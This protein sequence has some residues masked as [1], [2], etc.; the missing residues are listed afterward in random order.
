[1]KNSVRQNLSSIVT[2]AVVQAASVAFDRKK[3]LAKAL[4]LTRDAAKRGAQLVLF[5]E[6]TTTTGDTVLP[7]HP[8]LFA[9][10]IKIPF[11]AALLDQLAH[12]A[13]LWL[14]KRISLRW[15]EGARGRRRP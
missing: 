4:D 15:Y 11:G 12:E 5:P 13:L 10:C 8:R 7:F 6:G 2:V 1:M 3:T 9:G 14:P